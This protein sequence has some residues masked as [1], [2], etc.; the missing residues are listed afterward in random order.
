M[1][2]TRKEANENAARANKAM[3]SGHATNGIVPRQMRVKGTTATNNGHTIEL[4]TVRV[5]A[6]VAR[7]KSEARPLGE[8][9]ITN[10]GSS[11]SIMRGNGIA[12]RM[13]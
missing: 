4:F 2:T 7:L 12:S 3:F 10:Y 6:S 13:W 5:S 9:L 1:N 8:P 11:L